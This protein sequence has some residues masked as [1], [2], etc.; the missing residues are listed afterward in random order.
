MN[1]KLLF[2]NSFHSLKNNFGVLFIFFLFL[3]T[4]LSLIFGML[5][6]TF[7]LS[8]KLTYELYKINNR[9]DS[10]LSSEVTSQ[11]SD[12]IQ[13]S[14]QYKNDLVKFLNQDLAKNGF[15]DDVFLDINY[16][17]ELL[18]S[19]GNV[20]GYVQNV[21]DNVI[22][23]KYY[24]KLIALW[25]ISQKNFGNAFLE[26]V[27]N[28]L[29]KDDFAFN[30][31]KFA[32]PG[33]AGGDDLCMYATDFSD[34]KLKPFHL[35]KVND[36]VEGKLN[37]YL[38]QNSYNKFLNS[39]LDLHIYLNGST[40]LDYNIVGWTDSYF[41]MV[42]NTEYTVLCDS[43]ELVKILSKNFNA[44]KYEMPPLYDK[45]I[46]KTFSG[47]HYLFEDLQNKS[48]KINYKR[49]IT[50]IINNHSSWFVD[51][52]SSQDLAEYAALYAGGYNPMEYSQ[53]T[54]IITILD[55]VN[56][57]LIVIMLCLSAAILFFII[58]QLIENDKE[59]LF[60]LRNIG[61]KKINLAF[62]NITSLVYPLLLALMFSI[63]GMFV[64]QNVLFK[65]ISNA[66]TFELDYFKIQWYIWL[67]IIMIVMAYFGIF[68]I[69]IFVNISNS[70]L[71]PEKIY[72]IS[73]TEKSLSFFKPVFRKIF[74]NNLFVSFG[75][76][77]FYKIIVSFII[78]FLSSTIGLFGLIFNDSVNYTTSLIQQHF[79][80]Y[81]NSSSYMSP[82]LNGSENDFSVHPKYKY[83]DST[84]E[85][86]DSKRILPQIDNNN[87][88]VGF[89]IGS[90]TPENCYPS[91]N[92]FPNV[93]GLYIN[94]DDSNKVLNSNLTNYNDEYP[95]LI[96]VFSEIQSL[97][98]KIKGLY[99]S[100]NGMNYSAGTIYKQLNQLPFL[101]LSGKI[102]N[103]KNG[104]TIGYPNRISL[105]SDDMLKSIGGL[106]EIGYT[107]DINSVNLN[108]NADIL[109]YYELGLIDSQQV[110]IDDSVN[111]D[112]KYINATVDP[113]YKK[114]KN[115]FVLLEFDL[116]ENNDLMITVPLLVRINN[117]DYKIINSTKQFL[118]NQDSAMKLIKE[119]LTYQ[120]SGMNSILNQNSN[121]NLETELKFTNNII[122]FLNSSNFKISDFY[123]S[124]YSTNIIP[125]VY[126]NFVLMASNGEIGDY[127]SYELSTD[128]I[129]KNTIIS[130]D[131]LIITKFI[132][133]TLSSITN[134]ILN[135]MNFFTYLAV[136]T[137]LLL[138]YLVIKENESIFKTLKILGYYKRE[139]LG[140]IILGYV[141]SSVVAV[142]AGF[143]FSFLLYNIVKG[144]IANL[145]Q[146]TLLFKV[147]PFYWMI[148]FLIPSFYTFL[149]TT[150]ILIKIKNE[151]TIA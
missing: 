61:I 77:N 82:L 65:S 17:S 130:D 72:S 55:Y 23:Y 128:I 48:H 69:L 126:E 110:K 147:F 109:D 36:V 129:E 118:I 43:E 92:K 10:Q 60:F 22:I 83:V 28:E 79:Y 94:N 15:S 111:L 25:Q 68:F 121:D 50:S 13:W 100:F 56:I 20:D 53:Y 4:S 151:K 9:V 101:S 7:N 26:Y 136:F 87:L 125:K 148:L 27:Y 30:T 146:F 49:M 74:H 131:Y 33:F 122:N 140:Y 84:Y 88:L 119:N 98:L 67:F 106:N 81:K 66:Y 16:D 59:I 90:V 102:L 117:V 91:L 86:N 8:D 3:L 108:V 135:I 120:L 44:E 89:C 149:I 133:T 145:Y 31:T 19:L 1:L 105:V 116:L 62:I 137:L 34:T 58:K 141:I 76:K 99:P 6:L 97:Y 32:I 95:N 47:A 124:F 29:K 51:G 80:P 113:S 73:H 103:V 40:K 134:I 42:K 41:K 78:I 37:I 93:E 24:D 143:G 64:T 14:D 45:N 115:S 39:N 71:K 150:T 96:N 52:L 2:K 18:T 104:K 139:L 123:N 46:D 144:E 57:L 35:Y 132:K 70:N 107:N 38:T 12:K 127:S 11:F 54:L 5:G 138:I 21:K 85:D 63:L 75:F 142:V 114:L 112:F